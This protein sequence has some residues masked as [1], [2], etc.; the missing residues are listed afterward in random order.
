MG[1]KI[2]VL[3]IEKNQTVSNG[4]RCSTEY[5]HLYIANHCGMRCILFRQSV[6]MKNDKR[7]KWCIEAEEAYKKR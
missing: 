7:W 5:P 3:V 6:K 4:D 1:K 2:K